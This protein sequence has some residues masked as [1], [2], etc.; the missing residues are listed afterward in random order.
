MPRGRPRKDRSVLAR[1]A[2]LAGAFAAQVEREVRAEIARA[3][4]SELAG[5][6]T[7]VLGAI[8]KR[9]VGRPPGAGDGRRGRKLVMECPVPGCKNQSKG[10][11]FSFFCQDHYDSLSADEKRKAIEARK[12]RKAKKAGRGRRRGRKAA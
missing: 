12:A 8:G 11:R 10:P 5:L 1:F 6:S 7:R 4:Q 3:M 2:T 9:G